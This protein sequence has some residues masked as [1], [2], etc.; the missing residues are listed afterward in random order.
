MTYNRKTLYGSIR[1]ALAGGL[2]LSM[3]GGASVAFAQQQAEI[4]RLRHEQREGDQQ[5]HL[6]DQALRPEAQPLHSLRT[7]ADSV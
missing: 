2:A 1:T 4:D 5:D 6:A 7:S 3:A